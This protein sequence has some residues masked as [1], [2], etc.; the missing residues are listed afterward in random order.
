MD[1]QELGKRSI[2]ISYHENN[3]FSEKIV[4]QLTEFFNSW[5]KNTEVVKYDNSK[6][7][8]RNK[9]LNSIRKSN[10][11]LQVF[12]TSSEMSSW[13]EQELSMFEG[14][15][16]DEFGDTLSDHIKILYTSDTPKDSEHFKKLKGKTEA[17]LIT[18]TKIDDK[19]ESR[20]L[21]TSVLFDGYFAPNA[22]KLKANFALPKCSTIRQR[23]PEPPVADI[24]NVKTFIDN[25][26][27]AYE[28]GL[29]AIYPDKNEAT[30]S[31]EHR[32]V[33]CEKEEICMVGFTLR[34]YV[35][36]DP[37]YHKNEKGKIGKAFKQALENGATAKL[38]ILERECSAA[39]ERMSIESNYE[40]KKDKKLAVFYKDN[41]AVEELCKNNPLYKRKVEYAFY[42]TPYT[43][44][45]IFKDR[46]FVENYSLGDDGEGNTKE[47]TICGRV[48]VLEIKSNSPY[49]RLYKSHFDRAWP[50]EDE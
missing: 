19:N 7:V 4:N 26:L 11:L 21:I 48:P 17:G 42:K 24:K 32:L 36:F 29:V 43:G 49:Y 37:K 2:F 6:Q 22:A 8:P 1:K 34:R 23:T 25:Y 10:F 5:G 31:I 46:L 39:D 16:H 33:N 28:K 9:I 38:L 35:D 15:H 47:E 12:T 20:T 50:D 27:S 45:V 44:I 40:F 3:T 18:M 14:M 13:M 30:E 41:E